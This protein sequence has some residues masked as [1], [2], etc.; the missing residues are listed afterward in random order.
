MGFFTIYPA[1]G[2][3]EFEYQRALC[4]GPAAVSTGRRDVREIL[5][6]AGF[7]H[8]EETDLT[9]EFLVT[10]KAWRAGR[11]R[12]SDELSEA[13]GRQ[14]FITRQNES[15]VQID[16]IERGLLRRGLFLAW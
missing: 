2:L 12:H 11:Q 13:M 8:V 16:A 10:A 14:A 15:Q 4:S 3:D 7:A 5:R 9:A 6:S 1:P